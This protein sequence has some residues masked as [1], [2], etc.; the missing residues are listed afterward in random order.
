M[1]ADK[2]EARHLDRR[3]SN[4][5]PPKINMPRH[6][7]DIPVRY[8]GKFESPLLLD[9]HSTTYNPVSSMRSGS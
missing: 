5:N 2:V 1:L 3:Y 4:S 9:W 8:A 6:P 7:Q